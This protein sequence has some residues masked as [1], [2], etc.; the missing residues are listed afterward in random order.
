MN[1][2]R[3]HFT[4]FS[5]AVK[6]T[7]WPLCILAFLQDHTSHLYV[8]VGL[9]SSVISKGWVFIGLKEVPEH[10]QCNKLHSKEAKILLRLLWK[11]WGNRNIIISNNVD[12]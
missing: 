6:N 12:V 7:V 4:V 8:R 2:S 9:V 1:V 5:T 11:T 3:Q 10:P